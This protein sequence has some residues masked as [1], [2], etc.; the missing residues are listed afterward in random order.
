MID[1][2]D[3]KALGERML[4]A[5]TSYVERSLSAIKV[6]LD[7]FDRRLSAIPAGEKGE[8]GLDGAPGLNGKDGMP[9]KDGIASVGIQGK[10]GAPG[11]DGRDGREGADGLDGAQ[12]RDA[13]EIEILPAIDPTKS[14]PRGVFA[15]HCGGTIRAFRNTDAIT[16]GIE[17]AGWHVVLNGVADEREVSLDERT[18]ERTTVYTDGR[19]FARQFKTTA[20]IYRGTWQVGTSYARGDTVTRAGGIWHCE[21]DTEA[22]P[23]ESAHWK[24]AV[25][26]GN[27]GKEGKAGPAGERGVPGPAGQDFS[28]L[29]TFIK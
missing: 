10:E 20:M 16:D 17:K 1:D 12:G 2:L 18:V 29:G 25:K 19:T 26:K 24:L 15:M 22:A 7:E 3:M 14:Y 6:R 11:R 23:G 9:G 4:R 5:I 21:C 28:N 13:L 8:R 27:D